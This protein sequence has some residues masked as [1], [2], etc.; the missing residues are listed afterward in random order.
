ME[1]ATAPRRVGKT[2]DHLQ[3]QLRDGPTGRLIKCIGFGYGK[4]GTT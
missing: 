2:G 4:L 3:L 1:I